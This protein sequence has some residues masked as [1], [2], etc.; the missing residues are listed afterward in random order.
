[1]AKYGSYAG[2]Y[3]ADKLSKNSEL[4]KSTLVKNGSRPDILRYGFPKLKDKMDIATSRD[5]RFRVYSWDLE[6]GGTMH[7]FDHVV[8][9]I[10][11]SGKVSLW[12]APDTEGGGGFYTDV[13]QLDTSAGP[14]YLAVSTG[15]GSTIINSQSIEAFMVD[16]DKLIDKAN[17]IKTNKGLTN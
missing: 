13:F 14:I 17:V 15:I 10:G 5:G 4:I 7:D 6:D 16:G 3:D 11:K 1:M 8:Q 12:E 2:A 9:Y